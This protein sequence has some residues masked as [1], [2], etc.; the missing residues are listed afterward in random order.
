MTFAELAS[1]VRARYSAATRTLELR[2]ADFG[3]GA[4]AVRSLFD[5]V[6]RRAA[7]RLDGAIEPDVRAD[8]IVVTGT[9]AGL[10]RLSE[11]SAQATLL[12][13]VVADE[14]QAVLAAAVPPRPAGA[15][16]WTFPAYLPKLRGTL[17][18]LVQAEPEPAPLFIYSSHAH[19]NTDLPRY[20]ALRL[21]A[22]LNFHGALRPGGGRAFDIATLL[23]GDLGSAAMTGPLEVNDFGPKVHLTLDAQSSLTRWFGQTGVPLHVSLDS[24]FTPDG[25]YCKTGLRAAAEIGL[26]ADRRVTL[27]AI[28]T[29]TPGAQLTLAGEFQNVPVPGPAELAAWVGGSGRELTAL[30]PAALKE[31]GAVALESMWISL[32]TSAAS[33]PSK[34]V[35]SVGFGLATTQGRTWELVPGLMRLRS[36]TGRF[37]V[38]RPFASD[39]KPTLTVMG[40]IDIPSDQTVLHVE[41][42]I[43]L[44]RQLV[45]GRLVEGTTFNLIELVARLMPAVADAPSL[46]FDEL[47]LGVDLSRSPVYYQLGARAQADSALGFGFGGVAP[48]RVDAFALQLSN[49][50][51]G[52][53]MSGVLRARMHVFGASAEA[54]YDL[55]RGFR[56]NAV[57]PPIALDLRAVLGEIIG[58]AVSPPSWLPALDLREG[59]VYVEKD[60]RSETSFVF[61]MRTRV[62]HGD[63]A[64]T[65]AFLAAKRQGTWEYAAGVALANLRQIDLGAPLTFFDAALQLENLVLVVTTCPL[66]TNIFP[67]GARFQSPRLQ[68]A[69]LRLPGSS[70]TLDPG[71]YVFSRLRV[72]RLPSTDYP[73]APT[74]F[75][76]LG[77]GADVEC[78][79]HVPATGS[80]V[81]LFVAIAPAHL[82][83]GMTVSGR[84]GL[85]ESGVKVGFFVEG[86]LSTTFDGQAVDFDLTLAVMPTGA[87]LTGSYPGT[88]T[89]QGIRISR[90]SVLAGLDTAGVPSAGFAAEFTSG[91]FDAS[92]AVLLDSIDPSR[93]MLAAA[94]TDTTMADVYDWLLGDRLVLPAPLHDALK[95]VQVYGELKGKVPASALVN[96]L[97]ERRTDAV[98]RALAALPIEALGTT[99]ADQLIV[100]PERT[101]GRW[102]LTDVLHMRHYTLQQSGEEVEVRLQAQLY[103]SPTGATLQRGPQRSYLFSRGFYVDVHLKVF[104][105]TAACRVEVERTKGLSFDATLEPITIGPYLS[106]RGH[107][108][109]GPR[110]SVAT[111]TRDGVAPHVLVNGDLTLLGISATQIDVELKATGFH[112]RVAQSAGAGLTNVSLSADVTKATGFTANGEVVLSLPS[113]DLGDLG[114]LTSPLSPTLAVQI[115]VTPSKASGSLTG[116]IAVLGRTLQVN[117]PFDFDALGFHGLPDLVAEEVR[118]QLG[119]SL[120]LPEWLDDLEKGL[121]T[122]AST[123]LQLVDRLAKTLGLD[124][125]EA[126]RVLLR[127]GIPQLQVFQML[128]YVYNLTLP[129]VGQLLMQIDSSIAFVSQRLRQLYG[130]YSDD[131][132]ALLGVI[133]Y[134]PRDISGVLGPKYN[135]GAEAFV[136]MIRFAGY[137]GDEI[138]RVLRRTFGWP[139]NSVA[140]YLK[141]A[142]NWS[143]DQVNAALQ[144][145]GYAAHE[146]EAAMNSVFDW[147]ADHF[148]Y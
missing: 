45:T 129:A 16:P 58:S 64:P 98:A 70:S 109:R 85:F 122:W 11:E 138:A 54:T 144:G 93:S 29:D 94:I 24:E 28:L 120:P 14:P 57:L 88:F 72:D 1:M 108:E 134:G 61:A 86:R 87:L 146:V 55:G 69:Q 104:F 105:V 21:E 66:D 135:V 123:P 79:L 75:R 32:Q 76:L 110:L 84:L 91:T 145:A 52:G 10:P 90:L 26:G 71:A 77:L 73:F 15:P 107:R 65:F 114:K 41:A 8:A 95:Q 13:R 92:I 44:P 30:L 130:P 143:G 117:L 19:V 118:R 20:G 36:M 68:Q 147:F 23:L 83:G 53:A 99:A 67:D 82:T 40:T 39:R 140:G 7:V 111:Y 112:F 17:F 100:K 63:D 50:G 136:G 31:P 49:G 115:D 5:G 80:G 128:S 9:L 59:E 34:Q 37:G 33:T 139:A 101:P 81:R 35:A 127:L 132:A 89:F 42:G 51:P 74:L 60:S 141:S 2:P 102:Y 25:E 18:D 38:Y 97:D 125:G 43:A 106:F 113:V 6:L 119:G 4:T 124:P 148:R 96:A 137:G 116:S 121:I 142:L 78:T 103:C 22:G 27:E 126:M 133:G 12:M 131:M 3:A 46:V 62:G 48:V 47:S 56:V